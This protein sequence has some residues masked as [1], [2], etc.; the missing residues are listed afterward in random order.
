MSCGRNGLRKPVP[1]ATAGPVELGGKR[2]KDAAPGGERRG[3]KAQAS[4]RD[5]EC[6]LPSLFKLGLFHPFPF[7]GVTLEKLSHL[8]TS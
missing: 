2:G 4:S 8:K 1:E 3:G 6:P 5:G 7:P